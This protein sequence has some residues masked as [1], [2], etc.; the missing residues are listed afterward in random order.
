MWLGQ[1]AAVN[2]TK[3]RAGAASGDVTIDAQQPAVMLEDEKR[4]LPMALA[5]CYYWRPEKE[6]EALP[7]IRNQFHIAGAQ[8]RQLEPPLAL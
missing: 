4:T 5:G 3:N 7:V 6:Q 2:F 1:R 8:D